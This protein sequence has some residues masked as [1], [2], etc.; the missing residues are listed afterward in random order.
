MIFVLTKEKMFH[1]LTKH[2]K[3]Y[4]EE[5]KKD[6]CYGMHICTGLWRDNK[7]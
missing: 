6:G 5:L 4:I 3:Q 1:P 7:L 2:D